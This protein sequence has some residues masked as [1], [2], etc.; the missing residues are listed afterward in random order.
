MPLSLPGP[1]LVLNTLREVNLAQIERELNQAV[2]VLIVAGDLD[3]AKT[4]AAAL[5][6]DRPESLPAVN[7]TDFD[8]V[9]TAQPRPELA[10]LFAR[11][12]AEMSEARQATIGPLSGAEVRLL[13]ATGEAVSAA[14]AIGDPRVAVLALDDLAPERLRRAA[15]PRI[16]ELDRGMLLR[17][18]RLLPLFR[19]VAADELIQEASR[20]NAQIALLTS[21]PAN[22]PLVGGLAGD[23]ADA[24]ILTKN[25]AVLIF[26][27]A[28]VFGHDLADKRRL[29]LEIAPV[30]GG[31]FLW[32]S[33]ARSLVGLLPTALGG[34]SKVAVAYVGTYTVGQMARF[35]YAEGKRPSAELVARFQAEGTRRFAEVVERLRGKAKPN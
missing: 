20:A 27:L 12:A 2:Q 18:A 24:V 23:A 9:A 21:L 29:A 10:I 30:V 35:Y 8:G 7:L 1:L 6:G 22:I 5:L 34:L 15:P 28:G 16:A 31:A 19:P 33:L 4:L 13:I 25:Q 17:L 32:R 26:K 14:E 3:A 11:T